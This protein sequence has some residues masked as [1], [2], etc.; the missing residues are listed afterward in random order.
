MQWILLGNIDLSWRKQ[1]K[2][3]KKEKKKKE[4]KNFLVTGYFDIKI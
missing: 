1:K 2:N 3:K 4:R